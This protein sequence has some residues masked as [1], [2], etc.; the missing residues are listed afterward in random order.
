MIPNIKPTHE[1]IPVGCLY[2]RFVHL[3][4][5]IDLQETKS[6]SFCPT[7]LKAHQPN[8]TTPKPSRRLQPLEN[9]QTDTVSFPSLRISADQL[10]TSTGQRK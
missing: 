4:H 8:T 1:L 6:I 7:G 5:N 3:H 10:S 9:H 2:V